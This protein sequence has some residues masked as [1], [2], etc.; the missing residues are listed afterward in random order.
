[1]GIRYFKARFPYFSMQKCKNQSC[2]LNINRYNP[3]FKCLRTIKMLFFEKKEP[4]VLAVQKKCLPLQP[5]NERENILQGFRH[6]LAHS[7][8]G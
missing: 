1:M 5:Q 4:N 6:R 8:I 7:S 2:A 3:L